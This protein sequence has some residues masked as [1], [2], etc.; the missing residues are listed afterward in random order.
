MRSLAPGGIF[1]DP[2]IGCSDTLGVFD[3]S[4]ADS[5]QFAQEVRLQSDFSGP[6][7][8]SIGGNY[9]EFRTQNDYY[10]M[11]NLLTALARMQPLNTTATIGECGVIPAVAVEGL[12]YCP[13]RSDERRVG[14][15]CVRK[16]RC[17]WWPCH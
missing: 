1:C 6:F 7:N 17:R 9:T 16:C 13:Y 11:S 10:V 3:I 8:F 4:S 5:K 14:K 15:E 12:D 2:Q